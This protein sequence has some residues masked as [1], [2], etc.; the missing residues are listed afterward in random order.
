MKAF[1]P[2]LALLFSLSAAAQVGPN[3]RVNAP[4]QGQFGRVGNAIAVSEDGQRIVASWD[5][6]EG[7]C[8]P[9]FGRPC[10]PPNPPGLTGV[11]VSTD[12]G[13]TWTD[14][15]GPPATADAISGGHGWLDRGGR[16]AD[17][18]FYLVTRA[19][20]TDNANPFLGQVGFLFYRGR[21]ENGHFVWKD[22]RYFGPEHQG[23]FWRGPNVA[24]AKDGSR[25]VYI[26]LTSLLDVCGRPSSSGGTIQLLRSEDGGDTWSEPVT[27]SRDDTLVTTDPK[28]LL[29]GTWGH[30]QFTPTINLGPAGEI[31]VVW[32]YGPEFKIDWYG[33]TQVSPVTNDLGFS[34]S[35]DG[36]R[37][38]SHPRIVTT[39]NSLGENAPAGFSKDVMND[40]PR[41]AV[42][43]AGPHRGRL[44]FVYANAVEET[45]CDN[46]VFLPKGYTPLSSQVY[47]LWSDNRGQLWNGPVPL[48][49]PVPRMGVKRY[50]PTVAVR[51]DG[52]LDVIYFESHE[53]QRTPDPND[54]EC[55][56]PLGSG[57]FRA[58][59]A[60]SLVDL[61]WVRSKDGGLSFSQPVRITSQTSDWCATQFDSAG[62][63]FA[64]Y[65]DYMG[66]FP[67][68][69]RTYVLW[70]DGR[71]GVPEAYF[72]ALG[73]STR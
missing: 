66:I 33:L 22:S 2:V 70:T 12:G 5:D 32:Q 23:D 1:P 31:Y 58:G 67:G 16:G 4:Q 57:Y 41:L 55:P 28:D 49:P 26:A 61:W 69:D 63:L 43:Q 7:T 71:D 46:N 36:G 9:P 40:T 68:R 51:P 59:T 65:G 48:G 60:R 54:V 50:F 13:R 73:G 3:V 38:F 29:C 56:L 34:R 42:A 30:F 10:P 25:R 62:F 72:T 8:G 15:G 14:I 37:T 53:T 52:T 45:T 44:Y 17:E 24:A 35:L 18:T 11:A 64:N 19:R 6:S 27:V 20:K 47:L 21:F 39:V